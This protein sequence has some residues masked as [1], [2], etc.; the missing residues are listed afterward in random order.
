[1]A[2]WNEVSLLVP[3]HINYICFL[4]KLLYIDGEID[5]CPPGSDRERRTL[6]TFARKI[7]IDFIPKTE[8]E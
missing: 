5:V 8:I 7:D 4:Y 1:M 3:K 2:T 6:I